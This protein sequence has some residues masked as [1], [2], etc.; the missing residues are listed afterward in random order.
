MKKLFS[1]VRLGW[2]L[3]K[4]DLRNRFASS[5][6][7]VA[8]NVGVP[9]L[10]A[11][12]NVVVFSVLMTGR[13]G[14]RYSDVP[15]ALF[16]FVPFVLWSMFAEVVSRSTG[17]IKEYSY[18]VTKIAFPYWLLPLV[19]FASAFLTQLILFGVVAVLM[20][21]YGVTPSPHAWTFVVLWA[22]NLLMT[23]GAAYLI[24]AISVYITDMAQI[25]P[26]VINIMFWL[27]PILYPSALV[28]ANGSQT[29]RAVAL[30]A[31]P[32]YYLVEASRTAVFGPG[33]IS[34]H[35]LV[36]LAAIVATVLLVG[37]LVYRKLK[38]GFAD[39]L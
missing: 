39:V 17:I 15:F 35:A 4:R 16:Y 27:T 26:V 6:L 34:T 5:Y 36:L 8:W 12:V 20:V 28:E 1:D 24:S 18:L 11:L 30:H 9:L 14:P 31:N 37:A 7:G 21:F 22:L 29:F 2:S 3:A 38:P 23:I 33:V 13:M 19:P 10:F 25:V 32:F